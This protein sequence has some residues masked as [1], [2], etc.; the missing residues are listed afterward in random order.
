MRYH[1]LRMS[2]L[3]PRAMTD[4]LGWD[5][6]VSLTFG[7]PRGTLTVVPVGDGASIV[8]FEADP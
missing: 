1:P 4:D 7:C 6:L 2:W 5:V 8:M 3:V